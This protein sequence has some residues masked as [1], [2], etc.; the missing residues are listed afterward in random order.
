MDADL[1][2]WDPE[3]SFVVEPAALYHRHKATPYEGRKLYGRVVATYVRGHK[4]Y[5][6][7]EKRKMAPKACGQ[8][9]LYQPALG[10]SH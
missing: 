5:A 8:P 9:V 4:V 10:H 2:V 7:D 3:A 1:V 6:A